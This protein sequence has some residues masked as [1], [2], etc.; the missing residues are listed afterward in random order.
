ME[1]LLISTDNVPSLRFWAGEL[2]V[3]FPLLS[4]FVDR[5]VVESYGVLMKERGIA[6]RTTFVIGKDG[7][8]QH[9]EEGGDAIDPT[10]ALTACKRANH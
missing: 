1:V 4:D 2:G 3:S 6:S 5:K 7:R 9:I 10:G 8:I